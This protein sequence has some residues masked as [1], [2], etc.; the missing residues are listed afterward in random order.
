MLNTNLLPEEEKNI[1]I[2]ERSLRMIKFFGIAVMGT[3]ITG[4]ALLT[5]SYLP[6]YFQNNELKHLL[7]IQQE[8]AEK[9]G[10][11]EVLSKA[12]Y[13]QT[14]ISS[15][16]QTADNSHAALDMFDLLAIKQPGIIVS[17]FAIDENA[18]IAIIGNA[19]TRNDL[20]AFEQRLRDS[21]RFQD[22]TSSLIDI[23]QE[24]NIN[25]RLKGTLKPLFA[26]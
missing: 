20:L 16:R 10:G 17:E 12:S 8:A 22:I 23:I 15:L 13:V 2:L 3:L 5:P 24:I 11:G 19:A 18:N 21:S 9:M 7:S 6:L 25:F 1:I 4:I 14:T 26:P